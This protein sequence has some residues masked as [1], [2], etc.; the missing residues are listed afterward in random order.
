MKYSPLLSTIIAWLMFI[1]AAIMFCTACSRTYTV[2]T[3]TNYNDSSVITLKNVKSKLRILSD[4]VKPGDKIKIRVYTDTTGRS[5][6]LN[7]FK[8]N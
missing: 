1:A 2:A 6:K 8:T 3:V 7:V 4:T 5:K